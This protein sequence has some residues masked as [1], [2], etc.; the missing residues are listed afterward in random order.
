MGTNFEPIT[1]DVDV[2]G[3]T[4]TMTVTV[5][6]AADVADHLLPGYNT[7]PSQQTYWGYTK[8]FQSG[9]LQDYSPKP[10]GLPYTDQYY[11]Y[12]AGQGS[13]PLYDDVVAA[14][15]AAAASGEAGG[16]GN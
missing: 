13:N 14:A 15:E 16:P 3:E 12:E 7:Y 6:A 2:A 9:W 4:H 1:V 8:R 10:E 11:G 5:S